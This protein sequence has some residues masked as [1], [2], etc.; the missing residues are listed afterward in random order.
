M[1]VKSGRGCHGTSDIDLVSLC[2]CPNCRDSENKDDWD[3]QF[4]RNG[5]SRIRVM[6]SGSVL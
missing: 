5:V 4:E 2:P 6:E 1:G 3:I